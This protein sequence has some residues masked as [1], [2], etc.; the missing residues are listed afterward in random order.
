MKKEAWSIVICGEQEED[1]TW[2][3]SFI[4]G[5]YLKPPSLFN[6]LMQRLFFGFR[7][8]RGEPKVKENST[9]TVIS[10]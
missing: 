9:A 2:V 8:V 6:R 3:K 5:A 7:W 10:R 4:V 1:G